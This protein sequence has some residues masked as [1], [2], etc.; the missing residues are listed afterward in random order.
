MHRKVHISFLGIGFGHAMRMRNIAAMLK[1]K[2][3]EV[4]FSSSGVPASY[5]TSLGLK[6]WSLE[7]FKHLWT[8][9]GSFSF[10]EL[11][12]RS[13]NLSSVTYHY[14]EKELSIIGKM[15]PDVLVSDS[16]L[17]ALLAAKM[18][19]IKT[20]AITNQLRILT[21]CAR[22]RRSI[23]WLE[24]LE[25]NVL[26]MLWRS[27]DELLFPD[28]PPPYTIS[29]ENLCGITAIKGKEKFIG[30][31]ARTGSHPSKKT[32]EL[33]NKMT[34]KRR[35]TLVFAPLSGPVTTVRPVLNQLVAAAKE[36][37]NRR[38]YVIALGQP[39][40]LVQRPEIEGGF[41]YNWCEDV[42]GFFSL[43]DVAV[44]RGGHS[45]IANCIIYGKPMIVIP[46][47]NHTEQYANARK[48]HKLGIGRMAELKNLDRQRLTDGID[49]LLTDYSF[50][51]KISSLSKIANRIDGV[52]YTV[53]QIIKYSN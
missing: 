32:E 22:K 38:V 39:S 34:E 23:K 6:G 1:D 2:G 13:K 31:L 36:T 17:D 52:K 10:Y 15:H 45:S 14:L 43:A 19:G 42:Q 27:S 37:S 18:F 5:F 7:D 30:F 51:S 40:G 12:S 46:I 33:V 24:N 20:I 16:R 3:F 8:A 53:D 50:T 26:G 35:K 11:I 9:E 48:V 21:T 28:L 44:I 4:T 25:A 49:T 29:E 47:E 41:V